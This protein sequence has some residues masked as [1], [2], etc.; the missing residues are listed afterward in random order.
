MLHAI[1]NRA[2]RLIPARKVCQ[3]IW[4]V[5]PPINPPV[6]RAFPVVETARGSKRPDGQVEVGSSLMT[7][8]VPPA[9]EL[10]AGIGGHLP[11]HAGLPGRGSSGPI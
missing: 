2:Y 6:L 5:H 9:H 8:A 1:P 11:G 7:W 4:H 10:Q 3:R